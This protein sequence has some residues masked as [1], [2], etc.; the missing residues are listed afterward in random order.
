MSPVLL[1][2]AAF[3][4]EIGKIILIGPYSSYYSIVCNH[5]YDPHFILGTVPHSMGKYDLP[6]LAASIAPRKLLIA[7][8]TD[9]SGKI[10]DT[11]V[12]NDDLGIITS[13]YTVKN[14]ASNLV[15]IS[16]ANDPVIFN[17]VF[18]LLR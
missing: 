12:I 8:L 16:S 9:G 2:A 17:S 18:E 7:G 1:H 4:P 10:S 14:A 5:F 13:S 11:G 15:I 3:Y 6:D